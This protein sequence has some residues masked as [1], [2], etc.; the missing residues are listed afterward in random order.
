MNR[1]MSACLALA[2][3]G[4]QAVAV[5]DSERR[6][7]AE[8][9]SRADCPAQIANWIGPLDFPSD[10]DDPE[11]WDTVVPG[12]VPDSVEASISSGY[13]MK[14]SPEEVTIDLF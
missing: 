8:L 13:V 11:H 9:A 6:V 12:S 5:I 1:F 10:W 14:T 3:G 7:P 4:G 2:I